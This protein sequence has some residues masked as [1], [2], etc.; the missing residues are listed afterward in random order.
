M[1][2][3]DIEK[4][5][6]LIHGRLRLG[7][8]TYL[9][10]AE[11]ASFTEL[12]DALSATQ[13]NLSIQLRKLEDAG[14]IQIEKKFAGRKPLTTARLTSAGRKAFAEYLTNLSNIINAVQSE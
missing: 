6:E 12:R 7:I 8:M 9:A 1:S 4:I 14:F 13:G 5:D 3:F 2:E 11:S 10:N